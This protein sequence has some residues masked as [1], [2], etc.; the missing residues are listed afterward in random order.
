MKLKAVAG[1]VFAGLAMTGTAIAETAPGDVVWVDEVTVP[2]SLTGAPGNAET[3]VAVV[4]QRSQ[5][6]CVACHEVAALPNVA[7]QGNIG[8]A[9]DGVG[10]RWTEAELRGLMV[11]AK[12]MFPGTRMPSFYRT[13]GFIRPGEAYTGRASNPETFGPLL[14]AQQIEDTIAYLMTLTD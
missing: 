12:H 3:G 10:S 5:G 4:S 14:S 2:Q 6:N 7:F 11:D 1:L 9:L 8:P 13:T